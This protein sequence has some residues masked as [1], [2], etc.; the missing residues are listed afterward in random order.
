MFL[1]MI[2]IRKL[3]IDNNLGEKALEGQYR[4]S[5]KSDL[6]TERKL[7][8]QN[9]RNALSKMSDSHQPETKHNYQSRNQEHDL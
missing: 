9:P 7:H 8:N 2:Y 5:N 4:K 1:R 6:G 3:Q